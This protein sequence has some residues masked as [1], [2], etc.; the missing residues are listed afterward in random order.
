MLSIQFVANWDFV[1]FQSDFFQA[2]L[3][4][5]W[6]QWHHEDTKHKRDSK[7]ALLQVNWSSCENDR[8]SPLGL[9]SFT[10]VFSFFFNL[11]KNYLE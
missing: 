6:P 5:R 1:C 11:A 9:E 2:Q 4:L 3:R 10:E 8:T 7:R